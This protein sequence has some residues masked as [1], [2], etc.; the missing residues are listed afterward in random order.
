MK[1]HRIKITS[2][3]SSFRYPNVISGYQPTLYVPPIST[4]LGI[5]N[6]CAG[7]YNS[8]DNIELGYYFDYTAKATDLET[9]YQISVD[10]KGAPKKQVKANVLNRE[11]LLECRLYLYLKDNRLVDYFRY[12]RFQILLGRSNDL[13][14]IEE[15]KECELV[16]KE[17]ANMIRGQIVPFMGNFLPG[18]IQALPKYFTDTI[19]RN[20]I[21]T[22]A[23]S[24][25]PYDSDSFPTKLK[26]YSDYIDNKEVDIYF[27]Q[28]NFG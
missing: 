28:L 1:V 14:T 9:V 23:Y 18:T 11:F 8:F 15:I 6:A 24:V 16:E 3:T 5:I 4:V 17:N 2:W 10:S 13:A 25:I 22:E 19:P 7:F 21:G 27:H 26:A 20:N 12:P